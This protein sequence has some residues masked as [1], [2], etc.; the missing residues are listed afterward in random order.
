MST[1]RVPVRE[2]L[3]TWPDE[4][5]RLLGSRCR[6]CATHVFPSQGSCPRCTGTDVEVVPLGRRGRLWAWTIQG[7]PPKAPPYRGPVDEQFRPFGVGYVEL[8]G[9]VR[10]ESRLTVADPGQLRSGMEMELAIVPFAV[11]DHGR[12]LLTFAFRPWGEAEAGP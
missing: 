7:F 1:Q 3:F 11:D 9:Q 6:D 5:P 2:G 4:N 10:V 12:Q 8:P